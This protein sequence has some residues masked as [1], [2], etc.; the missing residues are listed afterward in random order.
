[1]ATSSTSRLAS[2]AAVNVDP[3]ILI[4]DEVLAVGDMDFQTKCYER[5]RA[6]RNPGKTFLLCV[7]QQ[8]SPDGIV[9]P[10]MNSGDSHSMNL[11]DS[12]HKDEN[13]CGSL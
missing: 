13:V 3:E 8:T 1:L 5:M 12:Y 2:S 7:S 11:A 9:R 4:V 10:D 6:L